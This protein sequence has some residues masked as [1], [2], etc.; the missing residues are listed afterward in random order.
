MNIGKKYIA[1]VISIYVIICVVTYE[2]LYDYIDGYI[3][4][5]LILGGFSFLLISTVRLNNKSRQ[6]LYYELDKKYKQAEILMSLY[7]HLNIKKPLPE[8]GGWAASPDLLKKITEVVLLRE[9]TLIVEASSGVSSLIIGY[10]LKKI[11]KGK[12]ISLEHDFYYSERSK[13][14][15]KKHGLEDFVQIIYAPLTN[16]QINNKEWLWYNIESLQDELNIDMIVVD[17]PP[18]YIQEH[19]R[20]PV[21]PLLYDK[22]SENSILMLDDGVREEEKQI[23]K[24]WVNEF[25]NISMEFLNFEFGAFL[26]RKNSINKEDKTLLAFTTANQLQYNVKGIE[27]IIRNKPDNIDLI[28]FDDASNDGTVEWCQENNISIVTKEK[29][30]GLTHSWNL[31]YQIFKKEGYKNIIFANSDIIVPKGALEMLLKQNE[32]YII[33]SP[34]STLKGVGHQPLQDVRKY[35][36]LK[37]DEYDHFNTQKIQDFINT[38]LNVEPIKEIDYIN[39]YFFSVNRDI[40]K[41]E[42]SEK[43]LFNPKTI[44]V[45]NEDDLC[46]RVNQPI[47]IVLNSYIFHFKGISME[48]T[49]M[50]NQPYELNIY[51]DLNWQEAEN[52]KKSRFKKMWFKINHRVKL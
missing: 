14:E 12:V 3:F 47:A 8:T 33:V 16:Y 50:D 17:G 43:E 13:S 29:A 30:L 37:Y 41:Y 36:D 46:Y 35:Y 1:A 6:N 45:G 40:I 51:R 15:V 27:S 20:Y 48:V 39:G 18:F 49:N 25:D 24:Q 38:N 11:G 5:I 23:I 26:V 21:I 7:N 2:F 34:L 32:K 44:N 31:A 22:M 52:L 10:C 42:Y 9:P 19:S 28:V 4:L